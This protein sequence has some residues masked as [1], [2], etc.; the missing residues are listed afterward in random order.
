M[1]A[2]KLKRLK[3]GE[4]KTRVYFYKQLALPIMGYPPIPT[5]A[6]SKIRLPTLQRIQARALRQAYNDTSYPLRF[7]TEE[8][9]RKATQPNKSEIYPQGK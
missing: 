5:H 9:H 2:T 1:Q 4:P 3:A 7:T 6:L 8:L